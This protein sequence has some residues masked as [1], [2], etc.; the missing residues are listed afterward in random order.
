METMDQPKGT[1]GL[2]VWDMLHGLGLAE[3]RRLMAR[4]IQQARSTGVALITCGEPR[5]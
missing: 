2:E 1:G 3:G 5:K 4:A